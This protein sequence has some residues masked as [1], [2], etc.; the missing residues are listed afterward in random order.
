VAAAHP[1]VVAELTREA[2]THRRTVVPGEPLFRR[3]LAARP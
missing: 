2:E 1:D 3:R